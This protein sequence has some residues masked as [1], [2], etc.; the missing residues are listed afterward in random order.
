MRSEGLHCRLC[1]LLYDSTSSLRCRDT[2]LDTQRGLNPWIS[3]LLDQRKW[4]TFSLL[5]GI[6]TLLNPL[7]YFHI[8]NSRRILDKAYQ[9]DTRR[10]IHYFIERFQEQN[11]HQPR[12][13]QLQTR[14]QQR[15][16]HPKPNKYPVPEVRPEP[17]ESL[18]LR[19]ARRALN[20]HLLH[21]APN[22]PPPQKTRQTAQGERRHPQTRQALGHHHPNIEPSTPQQPSVHTHHD[23]RNAPHLP[24]RLST[25]QRPTGLPPRRLPRPPIPHAALPRLGRAPRPA[26]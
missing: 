14:D 11:H 24:R 1:F 4:A 6:S 12:T 3:A 25:P 22:L 13:K 19:R 17:N 16:S 9:P 15:P 7:R 20:K 18:H 21:L 26:P 10:A 8:W 5:L 2:R 23:Q